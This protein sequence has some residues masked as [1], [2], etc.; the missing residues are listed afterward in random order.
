MERPLAKLEIEQMNLKLQEQMQ[1]RWAVYGAAIARLV[2]DGGGL[3]KLPHGGLQEIVKEAESLAHTVCI[4]EDTIERTTLKELC[5]KGGPRCDIEGWT[6]T[7][8]H[9][10]GKL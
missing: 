8:H 2:Y 3:D 5:E 4:T 1:R 10:E 7:G 6:T 9:I